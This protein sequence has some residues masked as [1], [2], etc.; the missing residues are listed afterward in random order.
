MKKKILV[1]ALMAALSVPAISET[2]NLKAGTF[3]LAVPL[4]GDDVVVTGK[5]LL[6][7]GLALSVDLGLAVTDSDAP[8][9]DGDTVIVIGAGL[10]KYLK[11]GDVAPFAGARIQIGS[12]DASD[13]FM[14]LGEVG[15]EAF[16]LRNFSIE[17]AVGLGYRSDESRNIK[18]SSFGTTTFQAR[19]NYYF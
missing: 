9:A 14:L 18:T 2:P 11:T 4:H 15:A 13:T 7:D 1:A 17:G 6:S 19:L 8:G 12:S 10:R 3:G 5:Y 16:L